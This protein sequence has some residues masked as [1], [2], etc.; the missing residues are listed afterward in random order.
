VR[1]AVSLCDTLSDMLKAYQAS[2]AELVG[3]RV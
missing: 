2:A 1:R 3:A